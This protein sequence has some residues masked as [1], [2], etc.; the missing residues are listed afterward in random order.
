MQRVPELLSAIQ[1]RVDEDRKKNG[2]FILTL[3]HQPRLSEAVAQSLAGRTAVHTLLP[4]SFEEIKK[5]GKTESLDQ[6]I[7]RGFMPGLYLDNARD[8][9]AYYRDCLDRYLERDLRQMISQ[10]S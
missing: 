1:V 2:R 4:L 3:S 7:V 5:A 9:H 8:P 6:S 10:E